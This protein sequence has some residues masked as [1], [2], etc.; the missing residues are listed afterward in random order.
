M[1]RFAGKIALAC[2]STATLAG[3]KVTASLA[4]LSAITVGGIAVV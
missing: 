1:K 2:S 4:A 3:P